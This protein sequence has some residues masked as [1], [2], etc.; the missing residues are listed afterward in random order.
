MLYSFDIIEKYKRIFGI[1][2]VDYI[3]SYIY[4]LDKY[5]I[6]I[7]NYYSGKVQTPNAVSFNILSNLM[8]SYKDLINL[9]NLNKDQLTNIEDWQ[10]LDDLENIYIKLL[11][12]SNISKFLRSSIVKGNFNLGVNYDY[13]LKYGETLEKVSEEI[14]DQDPQNDW[15][16]IALK[17]DLEEEEYTPEG[18]FLLKVNF[19]NKAQTYDILSVIDN[20]DKLEK[21]NG[22]DVYRTIT[23]EN[24][25]LKI[26]SYEETFKQ[27]VDIILGLQK[28]DNPEFPDDGFDKNIL[29]GN[30]A[31]LQYP[32]FFR[33][34]AS[35]FKKDDTINSF[36]LNNI[37]RD[38]DSFFFEFEIE[39]KAHNLLEKSIPL[40]S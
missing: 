6:D 3:G 19:T 36:T 5:S 7:I 38:Q 15:N 1:N 29:G 33:Q 22:L 4:F 11:S 16:K 31:S 39:S 23:F 8:N 21:V 24:D 18:G 14:G 26:L 27:A 40:I 32:I 2:L 25:D 35:T 34:L 13:G 37:K 17:N 20:I 9:M 10:I 12:I 28:G 30:L